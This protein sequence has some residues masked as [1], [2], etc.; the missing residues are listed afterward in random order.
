MKEE[1]GVEEAQAF[2]LWPSEVSAVQLWL[3]PMDKHM[4]I[5]P[6]DLE[7]QRVI[8][9]AEYVP[10]HLILGHT[11]LPVAGTSPRNILNYLLSEEERSKAGSGRGSVR[12]H[13]YAGL[14]ADTLGFC[15][16]W[17]RKE[18]W[19]VPGVRFHLAISFVLAEEHVWRK[20]QSLSKWRNIN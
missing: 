13:S 11:T 4:P 17:I 20:D 16:G 3:C 6:H 1:V 5:S 7:H 10:F 15:K 9:W 18:Y 19:H 14:S 8:R 2:R 12:T